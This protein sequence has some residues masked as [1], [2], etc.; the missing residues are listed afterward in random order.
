MQT[1]SDIVT[2]FG[3]YAKMADAIGCP[4]GTVSAWKTR[5][6][7]PHRYWARIA[8]EAEARR[9]EGVSLETLARIS[10]QQTAPAKQA[11]QAA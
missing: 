3:S 7:I 10:A 5:N 4:A 6:G 8:A 11:E 1:F 9:I 2:A